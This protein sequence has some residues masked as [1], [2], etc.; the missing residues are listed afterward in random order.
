MGAATTKYL[1]F[2]AGTTPK[3]GATPNTTSTNSGSAGGGTASQNTGSTTPTF[4]GSEVTS[5]GSTVITA[6][7]VSGGVLTL[8][9]ASHTHKVTAAGTVE[10]HTHTYT[11]PAAHTHTYDK[12]TSISLT[13]G[14]APSLTANTTASG[15]IQYVHSQGTFSAGTTPKESASFSG[16][17][18]TALVTGGTTKYMKFSA[19]TTP[20]S[21][22]SFAGTNSKDVVTDGT[23]YYLDH[24]HT[25]AT[26]TT[27]Y[28]SASASGTAVGA[29]GI[30]S[31]APYGHTHTYD[32][33]TSI[34][35]TAGTAPSM[36]FNTGAT[37]DTPYISAVSGGS[38]VGATTKYLKHTHN[39]ASAS[40]TSTVAPNEHTHSYG[41]TTALTTSANS[42]SAVAAITGL[43]VNT[44]ASSGDIT[45][46]ESATHTH[47]GASVKTTEDVLK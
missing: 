22:A 42:G 35:L 14:T 20:K 26:A 31:V 12:T 7:S 2:S 30:A 37:T 6:A 45:Y 1:H 25:G 28:L 32:K 11:K 10:A 29:T 40:G 44:T 16:T 8:T 43:T 38:A 17:A 4:T 33:T 24:G 34:T 41:S 13:D 19:G 39:A 23:T 46:V 9:S 15:G 36:N 18:T 5:G 21:S 47:T 3:S 27:K